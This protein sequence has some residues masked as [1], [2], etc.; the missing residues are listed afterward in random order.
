MGPG[1]RG[2]GYGM[3]PGM[4]GDDDGD[5]NCP[6]DGRS[7]GPGRGYGMMG[8]GYGMGNGMMMG[9]GNGIGP[10]MM[11][12]GYGMGPGYGR[13]QGSMGR[14]PEQGETGPISGRLE[15]P[16]KEDGARST[17]ENYLQSTRNP[18]LKLGKIT[19]QGDAFEAEIV[20]K[21]GSLVDKL[22]IEKSTGWMHPANQ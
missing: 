1:M 18:N 11:G 12:R 10:G 22:L 20:T 15:T 8:R 16:L 4:M 2:P 19:E 7:M 14:A 3:G 17:V 6:Y 5:W 13:G 21:D 9:R